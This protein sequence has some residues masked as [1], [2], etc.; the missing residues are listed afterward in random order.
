MVTA[1]SGAGPAA[2]GTAYARARTPGGAERPTR[3][4]VAPSV[5]CRLVLCLER[6][7]TRLSSA[8]LDTSGHNALK[9]S[10]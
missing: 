2:G 3:I 9:L 10:P 6:C 1:V 4:C 7:L 8:A 5:S